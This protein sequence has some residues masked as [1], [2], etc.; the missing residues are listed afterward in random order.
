[1]SNNQFRLKR[2][3]LRGATTIFFIGLSAAGEAQAQE[4]SE[5]EA[6]PASPVSEL[7]ILEVN[8]IPDGAVVSLGGSAPEFQQALGRTPLKIEVDP[9]TLT[10]VIE[11]DGYETATAKVDVLTGKTALMQVKLE[12][13]TALTKSSLRLAGHLLFWPGLL[14]AGTGIILI[15][16]DDPKASINTGMPGFITAGIGVAMTAVGGIILGL[17]SRNKSV[18]TMPTVSFMGTPDGHGGGMTIQRNF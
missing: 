7:G 4:M 5:T 6:P 16:V 15:A 11:L 1:M 17:T 10:L 3:V 18:Y 9:G 13:K 8:T 2:S 12:E 14:T